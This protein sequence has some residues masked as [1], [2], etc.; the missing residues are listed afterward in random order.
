KELESLGK[1][2]SWMAVERIEGWL[3]DTTTPEYKKEAGMLFMLSKYGHL[4][5]KGALY[6]Y[7]GKFLWYEAM[8]GRK[9]DELF[10]KIKAEATAD[11]QVFSE[12]F[13]VHMLMKQQCANKHYSGINRRSRIHKEYENKWKDGVEEE[14]EK[15]YKDASNKRTAKTMV[16]EGMGEALGGTTT[17]AL[18][19]A[20]KAVERGG[21][22][23]DMME[24]S[25]CLM[26][27]GA[28]FD[29]DQSTYL[30][31]KGLWDGDGQPVVSHRMMSSVPEMQLFN[32]TVLALSKE[33]A[34]PENYGG[35]YGK[36][37]EDAQEMF[38][39]VENRGNDNK[40]YGEPK[41]LK[42]AMKFWHKYG[43]ILSRGLNMSMELDDKFSK[44]DTIIKR[45]KGENSVFKEYY[46]K[47]GGYVG[48]GNYFKEDFVDD[49]AGETGIFGLNTYKISKKYLEVG[50]GGKFKKDGA[51]DVWVRMR[52][53]IN[54]TYG[55]ILEGGK[56]LDS[57]ENKIAQKE[58]I[59][60]QLTEIT[61]GLLAAHGGNK[62]AL[63]ALNNPTSL[64]GSQFNSWGINIQNDL[65]SFSSDEI[66]SGV[67]KKFFLEISENILNSG[68]TSD[69]GMNDG[70]TPTEML[71]EETTKKASQAVDHPSENGYEF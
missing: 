19:W 34:K 49:W 69:Q 11:N 6:P 3:L 36:I 35:Q 15:G 25:F 4:T 56:E 24:I 58:Y 59:S 63:T 54:A 31:M 55:K 17:N 41:R 37:Y 29:V 14:F 65:G 20:K 52:G 64:I 46:E 5:S 62:T 48:E 42:D 26:F 61:A 60:T 43:E 27:S 53:D 8:G 28:A 70:T 57:V 71:K 47:V 32:N 39:R 18:G 68:N 7:R 13:L 51:D 12:E 16:A 66:K 40:K 38:H 45:K 1:V 23:E 9:N 10:L 30:K 44:T 21:S 33:I 2:D 22:L 67:K 50:Q